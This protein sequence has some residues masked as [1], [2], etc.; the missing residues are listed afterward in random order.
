M[1]FYFRLVLMTFFFFI[2]SVELSQANVQESVI[3]SQVERL[4]LTQVEEFWKDLM[5]NYKGYLPGSEHPGIVSL[6]MSQGDEFS[7]KQAMEGI[8]SYFFHELLVNG[9]LLGTIIIITVFAMILETM[10]SAFEQ[11]S[12]SKTAYAISYMVLIILA[13]NSFRIAI[14]YAGEAISDMVSF[15][16]ALMPLVLAML[17]AMGN[18]ASVAMFHPLIIF[19]VN[20]SGTVI[21]TVIFPLLFLSSVLSIVSS[22][23]DK[24]KVTQLANL[25][26]NISLGLLGI[27][28]TIFLGIISVQG[29]TS[30]VADGIT[31]RTAK[32]VTSNFVPV[33][34]R[35]FSDATDTVLGASL[36]VKNA[37]GV[38]GVFILI[39][40]CAFPAIKIFALALVYN[41][42]AAIMQPLGASPII[43]CLST[44]GKNLMFV[45]AALA[46]VCLMFFLAVTI[47]ISAANLSIMVR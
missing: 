38:A 25:L 19:M 30:A 14:G 22:L 34:G 26:R 36:L 35:M 3:A 5:T 41:L 44:I 15:M 29:A 8:V 17:A 1:K 11:N 33:V 40:I 43:S 46:T 16:L 42:S 6:I 10:Q 2:F 21:S 12:V 18:F 23:S 37:V 4:D 20:V 9:K 32:Y 27:F 28:L 47:I 31:V 39:M 13:I 24:Y 45:F 7:F